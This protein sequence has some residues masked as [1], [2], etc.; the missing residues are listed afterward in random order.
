MRNILILFIC[1]VFSI[2]SLNGQIKVD[3]KKFNKKSGTTAVAKNNT[4]SVS[5]PAGE[6]KTGQLLLDLSAESPIIKSIVLQEGNTKSPIVSDVDPAFI[7]TVGKRDLVSQNGWNIFFD[8]VPNKPFKS[9]NVAI[10]KQ[11]ASVYSV[12]TR[13]LIS[14]GTL[15]APGFT[16][17]LEITLYNG[18]PLLNIAAVMSTDI[19]S[20]AILY[21]AGL[22]SKKPS[23]NRIGWSDVDAQIKNAPLSANDKATDLMVKYRTIVGEHDHG[24]FAVFPAP[25]QYFYPL[26]EAF[27]LKFVWAGS[28]YRNMIDG[29]GIGIR[30]DLYGDKRFVP[31]FNAP[32]ATKQRLNFFVLLNSGNTST[33]LEA[34]KKFTNADRYQSLPGYKTLTSHFHNEF[35]MKVVR[36]NK[37]VPAQPAF[38]DVFKKHGIDIVHLGEFHYTAHPKGPDSLR[39]QELHALFEQCERLSSNDLLMLPG[40]EPNEFFG[41]HWL[42]LFP[43]P[44]YWIMSRAQDKPFVSNDPVYGKVYR[45]ANEEEMLALLKTE[46]GL[47]WTAHPRTKGSTGYPDKYNTSKFFKDNHF[48][49]AA[50][51]AMPADLSL[52]FLGKRVLELMDD[53]N[54]WGDRKKVLAEA[55]LF[56][57]ENENEMYAHLNVNYIKLD[58]LPAFKDGWQSINDALQ[59]GQFFSSTGEVLIP[60]FTVDGKSSGEE[61]A[62]ADKPLNVSFKIKWTFPMNYAEIISG[63]GKNVYREKINLDNTTAFGEQTVTKSINLSGRKWVRLEAWDVAANGAFT[64]TIWIK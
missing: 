12:G 57:I 20:T 2:S 31:W 54:N 43:R 33:A 24:S 37:P 10:K 29:Y 64:Q 53:M 38:I 32:P 49:G 28:Q 56:T 7:L 18:S 13:T 16:G 9:Y 3:L 36:A 41:G 19:D 46:N 40:E 26:D 60:E 5:W 61:I 6:N 50:W 21:D 55:D 62:S 44:V 4:L 58:K 34:V 8:K 51:K 14:V 39:L 63:D 22:V 25:H 42:Q 45:I 47:A 35:I 17:T 59:N 15:S 27:N 52:P 48:L 30:Q 11:A 23:W 1:L